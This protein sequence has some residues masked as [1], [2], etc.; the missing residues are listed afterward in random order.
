MK[1]ILVSCFLVIA[2]FLVFLTATSFC[3]EL[4]ETYFAYGTVLKVSADSMTVRA[5]T[6]S[7]DR[8]QNMDFNISND[9][10]LEGIHSVEDI[11]PGQPVK[12]GYVLRGAVKKAIYINID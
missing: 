3:R 9:V 10:K 6:E 5:Y 4:D 8:E 2:L 12:V 1:K 11:K 7:S